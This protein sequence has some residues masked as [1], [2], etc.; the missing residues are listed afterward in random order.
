MSGKESEV[1]KAKPGLYKTTVVVE[2]LHE[3]PIEWDN[4]ED[5]HALITDGYCSGHYGLGDTELLT[6]EE[7]MAEL[8]KHNT[9]PE[10]FG[11]NGAADE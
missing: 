10:F 1:K 4:L 6:M 8:A 3:V 7:T 2:V 11:L 9:D 5:L